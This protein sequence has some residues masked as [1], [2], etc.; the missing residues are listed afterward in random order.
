MF[1]S[2]FPQHWTTLY[3]LMWLYR[4]TVGGGGS[5]GT[6]TTVT[7][8]SPLALVNALAKPIQSLTQY[9][10]CVQNGTPTP[11]APVPILCNNG[12]LK[13]VK[14]S[15][16]PLGYDWVE[17]ITPVGASID[18]G[19]KT[20]QDIEIEAKFYRVDNNAQTLVQS[21]ANSGGT[22]NTSSYIT[23]GGYWRFGDKAISVRVLVSDDPYT[24]LQNQ[25][26]V[27]ING[28]LA[29]TY[30]RVGT[31]TSVNNFRTGSG[32]NLKYCRLTVRSYET[33]EVQHDYLPVQRRSDSVYGFY[34]L[35]AGEFF[36]ND[37]ATITAG[38]KVS[39]PIEIYADGTPE[40]ISV[41]GQITDTFTPEHK[42]YVS[43]GAVANGDAYVG[44]REKLR[45]AEGQE[46]H[47]EW[48]GLADSPA[49][50]QVSR[51]DAD[52]N[53]IARSGIA[54]T[55]SNS[56]DYTVPR[57]TAQVNFT[58]YKAGGLT[59]P[60]GATMTVRYWNMEQTASVANLF[61]VGDYK[62]EVDIINGLLTH[63]VGIRVLDGTE[64]WR[65][66]TNAYSTRLAYADINAGDACI[67]THYI[68]ATPENG[69]SGQ[70]NM[71]AKAGF[72]NNPPNDIR[73]YI[74]DSSFA[75]INDFTAFLAAQYAAGTPVIVLYPLAEEVTEQ[76]T[77]HH[78]NS[79]DGTT[80]ITAETNVD[81]VTLEV[82]Y[83]ASA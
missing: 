63:N 40:V 15:G 54:P 21:D 57:G 79:Y 41:G 9:G 36:T 67:C 61:A 76:T 38:S 8:M 17:W 10:K 30:T 19:Y 16:L 53:F 23:N 45:C 48:S 39:D 34:D 13:A 47:V 12:V 43:T 59:I 74:K 64:S 3:K 51:W 26:G 83:A 62:D 20:T 73:L 68:G 28:E 42:G 25:T 49:S 44:N 6:I 69:L 55:S 71:S 27:W 72:K 46:L 70:P 14:P 37:Q 33:Q 52:G 11:D 80:V 66:H 82:E 4:L 65:E 2:G 75:T 78:L 56:A 7:G 60:E 1:E 24:S 58:L 77:P 29:G 5:S 18:F 35:I 22:T 31:F 50:I 81:P 32:T